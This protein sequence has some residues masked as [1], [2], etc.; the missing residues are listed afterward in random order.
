MSKRKTSKT[1]KPS[2]HLFTIKLSLPL[3][4]T[5]AKYDITFEN[6]NVTGIEEILGTLT[7]TDETRKLH[8]CLV[9]TIDFD[10]SYC[11]FWDRHPFTGT[12]LGCPI[13]YVP[14]V[15]SRTYFSEITKDKFTVKESVGVEQAV[16]PSIDVK[17]E[18]N[19]YY[20][21][22][23]VFCSMNC[24]WAFILENKKNPLY[25]D[26]EYL[27]TRILNDLLKI[28]KVI[29]APHWRLLIPYGGTLPIEEFRKAFL[30]I[31]YEN[32][33]I[34]KPFRSIGYAFEERIKL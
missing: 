20:E 15:V 24:M 7:Y 11:C 12:P 30:K 23:G 8:H 33:G 9:S 2:K 4:E 27:M 14:N 3:K 34:Y 17:T 28:T 16:H 19:N 21:T 5:Y 31:E 32:K 22:D 29:P 26:S 18:V 10:K 6:K 13:K 1:T 25:A